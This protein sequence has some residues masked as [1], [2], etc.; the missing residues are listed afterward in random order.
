MKAI[1][2]SL[3]SCLT[4][5]NAE[6]A[7]NVVAGRN[8]VEP[9]DKLPNALGD[10]SDTLSDKDIDGKP[11]S[12]IDAHP[13]PTDFVTMAVL[14]KGGAEEDLVT[15]TQKSLLLRA[16]SHPLFTKHEKKENLSLN[17]LQFVKGV[18]KPG[19]IRQASPLPVVNATVTSSARLEA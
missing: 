15:S 13:R 14:V 18:M 17:L 4:S 6:L 1:E 5:G 8:L 16:L 9:T 10:E 12:E 3:D 2:R 11:L 7:A 19:P